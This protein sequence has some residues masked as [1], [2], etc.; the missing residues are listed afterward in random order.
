MK[1][2]IKPIKICGKMVFPLF[3]GGK[4]INVTNG[5]TAGAWANAG[6]I[7][8]FSAV[9]ADS[10][11]EE[12]N[13]IPQ[14]Y[15]STNR[16]DRQKELIKYAID[17]GIS[18]AKIA[19]E[20]A[21]GNGLINMNVLWEMGGC[22][23]ILHGI[24][25]KVKHMIN[26]V[27]CG[28]GMPYKL[29]EI[30]AKYET[31]YFPIVSSA[32]A[33]SAL[34]KRSYKKFPH[35]LGGV[36]YEDPWKAGGHN[37]LSNNEDPNMPQDP[38]ERVVELRKHMN[39]VGMEDVPIIIAGGVWH[40]K[41]WKDY[42]DNE[43]VGKVA[44]QFGTRPLL[45]QES[46]VGKAWYDKIMSLKEDDVVLNKFSP[47]GF[48]SSAV[49]NKFM[50]ELY[51]RSSR[52]VSFSSTCMDDFNVE[53]KVKNKKFFM[54]KEDVSKVES[55][56]AD[57]FDSAM[58]T[59]DNTVIFVSEEKEK[60]IKKDQF[61]CMG[62]LSQCQFSNFAQNEKGNTGRLPD[63]RSFCIQK[64]LQSIGHGGSIEDNLMFSGHSAFKFAQ[65]PFYKGGFL[66]T[67]KELFDRIKT[68][69]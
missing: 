61:G 13:V 68:G 18:Q 4:G 69:E 59:P 21:A 65:D 50:K 6:G 40:L 24:L 15:K 48:Y 28:A 43:E 42:I 32:R 39:S 64:A 57:G 7:G 66:P 33:F 1:D 38:Y 41:D 19:Y 60:Q 46:P 25:S 11:D 35:L 12:G 36:V 47:T 22:E 5:T 44:F 45:T 63:P 49:N 52:Q 55:W 58:R 34:W 53:V 56:I 51:A 26:G 67:V 30:C 29:A 20:K 31:F 9:N 10:Y 62:C 27:T 16:M 54:K 2:I 3:E 8:T 37:G 17:G 14:V 23:E